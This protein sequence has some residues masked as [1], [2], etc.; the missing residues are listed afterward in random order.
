LRKI[1][2]ARKLA[3]MRTSEAIALHRSPMRELALRD[4]VSG[5]R[6]VGSALHRDDTA[7]RDLHG[8][9]TRP[10]LGLISVADMA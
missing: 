6:E 4:R 9:A 5:V 8:S 3:R 7:H 2:Y 1:K 10:M